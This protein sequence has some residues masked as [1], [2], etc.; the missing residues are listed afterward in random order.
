MTNPFT[1]RKFLLTILFTL[2][3]VV[4]GP[5]GLGLAWQEMVVLAGILGIYSAANAYE[6]VGKTEEAE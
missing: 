6:A 4:N 2:V 3:V 5:L 1:S